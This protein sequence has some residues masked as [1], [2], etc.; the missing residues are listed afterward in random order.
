MFYGYGVLNNHVPTLKATA[1]RGGSSSTLSTS[2]YTVYKAESNANDSLGTYNG[3]AQ[4]GLTYG[5]G[6][7]GNAFVFNGTDAIVSIPD[8]TF[9]SFVGDFSM[10]FD[11]NVQGVSGDSQCL[12]STAIYNGGNWY[13]FYVYISANTLEFYIMNG[14]AT[15][16]TLTCALT[17]Y[18]FKNITITRKEGTR[19]RIYIDG[20]LTA[21]NTSAV[22]P[23]FTTTHYPMIGALKYNASTTTYYMK[24]TGKADECAFWTKEL[25]QA[26]VTEYQ[27]NKYPF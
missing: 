15:I 22:N 6:T 4:G 23:V 13:G 18:T 17:Y 10:S 8:N 5:A 9:N 26:E 27:T 3:T 14:T 25:T 19:T 11:V 2:L 24:N 21:S 20:T 16:T 12:F 7:D 1:M